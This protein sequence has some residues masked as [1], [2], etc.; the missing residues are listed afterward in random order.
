MAK[1][2]DNMWN[3][4]HCLGALDGKHITLQCPINSGS[5][6]FNYKTSFSIVLMALVDAQY[7]FTFV[8]CGCQGR[9]S[10]GGVYRNTKLYNKISSNQLNIPPPEPLPGRP[11]PIPYVIVAD[12]AFEFS[13]ALMKP[14][15]GVHNK[16]S[17][18]RAFNYRI[19]RARR[20]VE[21]AFGILASVFRVFRKPMLLQPEKASLITMTCVLLHNFLRRSK[22]SQS[23]YTPP[24][25]FDNE[26]NGVILPGT[27]RQDHSPMSSLL[28]MQQVPR[29]HK[30]LAEEIRGEFSQYFVNNGK[31]LWQ[32]EYA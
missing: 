16:G 9:V 19:S 2:F 17:K 10:D 30:G 3:F 12:D 24:G 29:K 1:H 21:N 23:V 27:W 11:M 13:P 32:D 6:Y 15:R 28:P 7:C 20:V 25:T 26:E 22:T 18:E 5:E 14:Y 31:V 4:P 8:D